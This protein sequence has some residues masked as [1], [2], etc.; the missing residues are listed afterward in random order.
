[1]KATGRKA[2]AARKIAMTFY[3]VKLLNSNIH[4]IYSQICKNSR[5]HISVI[6]IAFIVVHINSVLL[7]VCCYSKV[8]IRSHIST[9]KYQ[10]K[11]Y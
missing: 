3:Y 8:Q 10:H 4:S 9:L 1:M 5:N 6:T 7:S 11:L 2:K